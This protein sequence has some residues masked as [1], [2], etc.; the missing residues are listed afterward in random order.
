MPTP[1]SPRQIRVIGFDDAPHPHRRGAAVSLCGV[2]CSATRMEGM[3]WGRLRRDGWDATA[4]LTRALV[5]SR[6]ASQV[7]AV[8]LDGVTFGGLNVVD[9]RALAAAVGVPCVA[10]MRR[11]P[12]LAAMRAALE[13]L[14]RPSGGRRCWR[15]PGRCTRWEGGP[16]TSWA[17]N[18][19]RRRTCSIG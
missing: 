12:D 7:H 9:L 14:P 19:L 3:V 18:L 15:A 5:G 17:S 8:L 10:V 4:G 11:P 6:Y 13:R 1:P 2:V 16:S